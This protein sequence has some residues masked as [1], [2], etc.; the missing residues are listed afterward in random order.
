MITQIK[1]L[2]FIRYTCTTVFNFQY[3]RCR[4]VITENAVFPS[5]ISINTMNTKY[6]ESENEKDYDPFQNRELEHPNS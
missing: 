6:K 5:T 2:L 3:L 1:L 4:A